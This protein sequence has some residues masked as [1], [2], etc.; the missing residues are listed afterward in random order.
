M[1]DY[2]DMY[3]DEAGA[4]LAWAATFNGE[5]DVYY[6][7]ITPS[8][9]GIA[10]KGRGSFVSLLENY[11]NPFKDQTN[12][13]YNLWEKGFISLKVY[14]LDGKEVAT[15]LHES[16]E[17]GLHQSIFNSNGLESGVYYYRLQCGDSYETRRLVLLK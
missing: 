3:S 12:I 2:Y 7:V 14:T 5:Q 16:Q 17:A 1:G 9:V 11:P 8:Y 13:R 6:S 15:L 4:H 10:E